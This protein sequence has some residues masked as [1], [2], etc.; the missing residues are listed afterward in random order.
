MLC[1]YYSSVLFFFYFLDSVLS[2]LTFPH[3][4]VR[5]MAARLFGLLFSQHEPEDFIKLS[6]ENSADE[7]LV[8]DIEK[9]VLNLIEKVPVANFS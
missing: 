9:K 1:I 8:V 4:W 7:Y 5:L 3:T 2:H 6:K